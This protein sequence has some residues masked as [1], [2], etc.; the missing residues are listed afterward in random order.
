MVKALAQTIS[1]TVNQVWSNLA[2]M[3]SAFRTSKLREEEPVCVGQSPRTPSRI[4]VMFDVAN[5]DSNVQTMVPVR[6]GSPL[7]P[8]RASYSFF[9]APSASDCAVTPPSSG[10][11]CDFDL[12]R[13]DLSHA[14][15]LSLQVVS[16]KPGSP[17]PCHPPHPSPF[18]YIYC[19]G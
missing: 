2:Y 13:S 10:P 12:S 18:T 9:R 8:R 7:A 17:R 19:L 16:A 6:E 11:P 3:Y 4:D 15:C 1:C 14:C 5:G